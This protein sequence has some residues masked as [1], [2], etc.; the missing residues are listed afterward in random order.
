MC[1]FGCDYVCDT[2]LVGFVEVKGDGRGFKGVSRVRIDGRRRSMLHSPYRVSQ[3][4]H[5]QRFVEMLEASDG[6]SVG[7]HV[8]WHNVERADRRLVVQ[9]DVWRTEW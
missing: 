3:F 8:K 5:G 1:L 6:E 9:D 7:Q 4:P 2:R